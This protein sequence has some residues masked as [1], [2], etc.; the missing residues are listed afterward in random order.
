MTVLFH[1]PVGK[2]NLS[3]QMY[4][5]VNVAVTW[6]WKKWSEKSIV[7]YV[8]SENRFVLVQDKI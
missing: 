7:S 2:K 6:F 1:S 4:L 5:N 8:L 3:F